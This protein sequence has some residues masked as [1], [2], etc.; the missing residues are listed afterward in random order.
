MT[1]EMLPGFGEEA[2]PPIN[3][4]QTIWS[5]GSLINPH[6][7]FLVDRTFNQRGI[8]IQRP[9]FGHG[10]RWAV[11]VNTLEF[12][13]QKD[14]LR[15]T[16]RH[17]GE[18]G[19]TAIYY[20]I[21]SISLVSDSQIQLSTT[22]ETVS[23]ERSR[24]IQTWQLA[25]G[26]SVTQTWQAGEGEAQIETLPVEIAAELLRCSGQ[27]VRDLLTRGKID[28]FKI[29]GRWVVLKTSLDNYAPKRNHK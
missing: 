16:H 9:N 3:Y 27:N 24:I 28:G 14:A 10:Y 18:A 22:G 26:Q 23:V 20:G 13:P 12:Y 6:A 11:G 5:K 4:P 25:D 17:T 19:A 29:G 7:L 1:Q 15:L 2:V 8:E 21:E